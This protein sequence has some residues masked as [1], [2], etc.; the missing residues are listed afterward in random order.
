MIQLKVKPRSRRED[1]RQGVVE[2]WRVVKDH[3][4]YE[5]T[6]DGVM[7]KYSNKKVI[8]GTTFGP[9]EFRYNSGGY[10]K[11][12]STVVLRNKAWLELEAWCI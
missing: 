12:V 11:F 2:E 10:H 7:R 5:I 4:E 1:I 8:P 6:K 3:P 9:F